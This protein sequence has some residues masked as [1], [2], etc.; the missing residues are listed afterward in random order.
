[1]PDGSRTPSLR[2]VRARQTP[3]RR[4]RVPGTRRWLLATPVFDTYW[5]FACERQAVFHA[6]VRG[7]SAPWTTDDVLRAHR[8]TNVYRA[9]D[10]VSQFLIRHV[11]Y[12]KATQ[13]EDLT[14]RTLLFKL[15]NRIETWAYLT[16]AVGEISWSAYDRRRL[17]RALDSLMTAG[18][19]VYSAAYIMPS[20]ALGAVR[21]HANHL[22]L[23][24]LMMADALPQRLTDAR[25]LK[26]VYEV[27]LGYPSLGPFLAFQL[28]IDLNYSPMLA[29]SEMDFVV[30]GPGAKSGLRKCF[31]DGAGLTDEELISVVAEIADHEFARQGL[32]FSDL[33]GRSLQLIDCQNLF[34]EVDKYARVAH[35]E[36]SSAG[37]RTRIKQKFS[38]RTERLTQWYPPKWGIDPG[39]SRAAGTAVAVG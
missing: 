3:A 8:F 16:E 10:R 35:P 36:A 1:M 12:E 29:F 17:Q 13:P 34:C 22:R 31:V 38:P 20:P 23:L 27:L 11:I 39:D 33:W 24:E 19:R 14:F 4:I 25:S 32:R 9:S 30:A 15:F 21:K 6:R 5:R 37:G 26:A 28:A 18:E 2:E 7:E